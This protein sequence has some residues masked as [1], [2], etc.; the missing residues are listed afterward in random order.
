MLLLKALALEPRHGYGVV[1]RIE[2]ISRGVFPV[3]AGSRF[4]AFQ[5]L[6]RAGLIKSDDRSRSGHSKPAQSDDRDT[7]SAP[8]VARVN[9]LV[10]EI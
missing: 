3:N 8:H 1:A 4:V 9:G 10:E 2:Q 6:H 7:P 5:R